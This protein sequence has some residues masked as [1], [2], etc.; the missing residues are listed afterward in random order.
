MIGRGKRREREREIEEDSRRRHVLE[1]KNYR[2]KERVNDEGND[3]HMNGLPTLQLQDREN[4]TFG[5]L[6]RRQWHRPKTQSDT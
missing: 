3:E 5:S 6:A 4:C 1:H 2:F